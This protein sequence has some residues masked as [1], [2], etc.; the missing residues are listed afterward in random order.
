[1]HSMPLQYGVLK[2]FY[3]MQINPIGVKSG[4][5]IFLFLNSE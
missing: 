3:L 2:Q 4:R 5:I 1:M